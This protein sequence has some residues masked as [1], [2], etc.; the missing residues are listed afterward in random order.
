MSVKHPQEMQEQAREF[1][2]QGFLVV[3]KA[4]TPEEMSVVRDV[5]R[6]H[7]EMSATADSA[8]AH[9]ATGEGRP[10]FA[11]LFVWNDTAGND[12]FAKA[13]RSHKIVDRLEAI[14]GDEVYVYHNKVALKYPGVV[15]FSYHQ[16]YAYWYKMGNL[17]PDMASV[18][19]AVDRATKANG[20]LKVIAGSHKLG[21]L[22][23]VERGYG[24]SGVDPERL[25]QVLKVMPE[26]DLELESGD[27]A[28]FHCN[29]LHAS[30]DNRSADARLALLGCFNTRHNNP[31]L[32]VHG[33]PHWH[34]QEKVVDPITRGDMNNLP[35]FER[36]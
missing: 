10:S 36:G 25:A 12:I 34:K 4:F 33:H 17:F 18:F 16:D 6:N 27:I 20:C 13:T 29:T 14:F 15:G 35:K 19:I 3:R 5:V 24:D 30:D 21:R 31:Y 7:A 2:E 11:T 1:W 8:K 28:L 32:S 26:V 23:H 9:S 22:D